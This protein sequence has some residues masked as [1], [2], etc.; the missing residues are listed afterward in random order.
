[1]KHY[2]AI[3]F[4]WDGNLAKTL[5]LWLRAFRVVLEERKVYLTDKEIG[6][7]F[8]GFI[9]FMK[10]LGIADAED[11]MLEANFLVMQKMRTIGLYPNVIEVL[12]YLKDKDKYLA[13]ITSTGHVHIDFLLEK[14][15]L[16]SYF[17]VVVTG[18]DTNHI[19]PHPEP[20]EK[21]LTTMGI[22]KNK[23]IL[24]GDSDKDLEAARNYGIDSILFFPPEHDKFYDI[25][26]LDSYRP[27]HKVDNLIDIKKIL[28]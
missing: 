7:G 20:I 26:M 19:K 5:D 16:K 2:Q 27:T 17:S 22:D 11:A 4:D 14:H 9:N 1:M 28:W 18:D 12:K 3:L 21:A 6:A 10:K 15:K 13:L 25:K 24:I 8:G 23:S